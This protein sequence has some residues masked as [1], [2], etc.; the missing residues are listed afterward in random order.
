ML[1]LDNSTFEAT[2][3]F[4]V[5]YSFIR[6]SM[7]VRILFLSLICLVF[8]GSYGQGFISGS[9]FLDSN[10]NGLFDKAERGIQGVCIS[11]GREVVQTDSAGKW[12][13]PV[14]ENRQV[15]VIKPAAYAVPVSHD[16]VPQHFVGVNSSSVNFPLR[17]SKTATKFSTVFFGD[18]QA[19]GIKE[20]NY[21]NHDIVEELIGTDALFGVSLGDI[22]ADGPALFGPVNQGIAQIGIPWYNTFGNHDFDRDAQSAQDKDLSFRRI[23]GPSTYA[24]EYGQVVF[25]DLNN[26]FFNP[27]GKYRPHFTEDQLEFV[28]NYLHFVPGDKLVVLMMHAPIVECDNREQMFG[29]ISDRKYTFSISGHVHEQMNLFVTREMGWKGSTAHHHLVNATVCGSWWCGLK[30][31]TGIPHA[32]MNDGVP[33]GYSIIIFDGP[34]Y[35]VRFKAARRPE[36]YQMNVYLPEEITR[37][38][39]DTTHVLVNVF[40]GSERS[41]VEMS[42]DNF[43]V[44]RPL[45]QVK[46]KD[47]EILRM[48]LLNPILQKPVDGQAVEDVLGYSMDA[49]AITNHMWKSLLPGEISPG[50][51]TVTV[52]TTDMFGQNWYSRK[53]FRIN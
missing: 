31:E 49:P 19:R 38:S 40:A 4:L 26:I 28:K 32:T 6:I 46:S 5:T 23:Y 9:V 29:L 7:L 44:W 14:S 33:N 43:N 36:N 22:T 27:D 3:L 48:H 42:I 30:D 37:E 18:P 12:K 51:H 50:T 39:V 11:N 8:T 35:S 1:K 24:F 17:S 21:I 13:L 10:E 16:Q 15:F 47:P 45:Q 20:V 52:K 25:I 41:V 2:S 34:K 53:I